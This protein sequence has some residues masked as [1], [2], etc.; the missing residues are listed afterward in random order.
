[1]NEKSKVSY[2]KA[3]LDEALAVLGDDIEKPRE[4]TIRWS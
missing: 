3:D 1:M 4:D 2:D